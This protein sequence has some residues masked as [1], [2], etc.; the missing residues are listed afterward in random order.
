MTMRYR[1]TSDEQLKYN[2]RRASVQMKQ[3]TDVIALA[4]EA[5]ILAGSK[6]N[7]TAIA[8]AIDKW[9]TLSEH[10]EA[11]HNRLL[12]RRKHNKGA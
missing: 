1:G 10:R 7:R 11:I 2:L 9:T 4:G 6:G 8:E 5:Y 12:Y 3:Q